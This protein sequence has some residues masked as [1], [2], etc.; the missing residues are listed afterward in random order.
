MNTILDRQQRAKVFPIQLNG[1]TAK[2]L[3]KKYEDIGFLYPEKKKLLMPHYAKIN[4]NWNKLLKSKEEL[5]WTITA[6]NQLLKKG[7][8]SIT[9]WKQG[10]YSLFSQ[11]LV[12]TGNPMLSLKVMMAAQDR[13]E[14]YFSKNQIQSCQNWFRPTNRY[15]YRIFAS[16]YNKLGEEKASLLM[17]K[18]LHLPLGNIEKVSQKGLAVEEI[19]GVDAALIDF[20]K[21]EYGMVFVRGEELDQ[22]DLQFYALGAIFRQY[23]MT[24]LRRILKITDAKTGKIIACVIANRAPLGV[25]FSFLENRSYYIVSKDLTEQQRAKVVATISQNIQIFYKNFE[26]Q[27]IPIVT[28]DATSKTLLTQRAVFQRKYMQTIWLR[29]GFSDW[30]NHIYSFLQKIEGRLGN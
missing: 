27:A 15:A 14:F 5:L 24:R 29:E 8:A 9:A 12:S 6:E 1:E 16:M 28:D 11:H 21:E 18:Y 23:S 13:A 20:V 3:F 4:A 10:N 26:L 2:G 17:F 19:L 30:Y 25:N 22:A 7:F